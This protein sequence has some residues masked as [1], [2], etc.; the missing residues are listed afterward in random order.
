[1]NNA[2]GR[3]LCRR[4]RA[5]ILSHIRRL[6]WSWKNLSWLQRHHHIPIDNYAAVYELSGGYFIQ[7]L[8]ADFMAFD[9]T[10][11]LSVLRLPYLNGGR[12]LRRPKRTKLKFDFR[13][14]DLCMDPERD[15]LVVIERRDEL[16]VLVIEHVSSSLI[17][18]HIGYMIQT[19]IGSPASFDFS[20][21]PPKRH[22]RLPIARMLRL[23]SNQNRTTIR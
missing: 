23:T 7:D 16:R 5:D 15:L 2:S 12:E 21:S 19:V 4:T 14:V 3:S 18:H 20:L 10:C 6:N 9:R 13:V 1:M 8:N 22:I 17:F 11:Q